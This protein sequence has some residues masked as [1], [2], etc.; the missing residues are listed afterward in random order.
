MKT[1]DSIGLKLCSYQAKLFEESLQRTECSSG[2]FIRRFMNS[3]LS[4]RM[5]R[6]GF[7]FEATN[8][9]DAIDEVEMQYGTSNYGR[10]KYNSEEMHWIGYIYRY[11]AYTHRM[12]S[13]R[14]YKIVK[15]DY[16]RKMYYPY[17][18]LDPMQAIERLKEE[19]H[20]EYDTDPTDIERGVRILREVRRRAALRAQSR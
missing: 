9:W 6:N 17:H 13:K 7:L 18:S 4:A 19:L 8:V 1:M 11:W 12:S 2:I 20:A 5:D 10:E 15:P 3:E 16:L 14:V